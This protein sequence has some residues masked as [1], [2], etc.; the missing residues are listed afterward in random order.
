VCRVSWLAAAAFVL[1]ALSQARAQVSAPGG[2]GDAGAG[3]PPPSFVLDEDDLFRSDPKT[4]REIRDRLGEFYDRHKLP[5]YLA[6]YVGMIGSDPGER[7]ED[8]RRAWLGERYGFVLVYDTDTGELGLGRPIREPGNNGESDPAAEI[9]RIPSYELIEVMSKVRENLGNNPDRV[10]HLDDLTKLL[11]T[12]FD[13]CLERLETPHRRG[14]MLMFGVAV[15]GVIAMIGLVA[16]F[17]SRW[18]SRADAQAGQT[19]RFPNV[20]VG[21][22]LGAP[23]GGGRVSSREFREPGG[24][25]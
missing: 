23:C 2:F 12:E 17:A 3:D 13:A 9:G 1:A 22:R 25:S 6:V 4:L 10:A 11:V 24:D 19:L 15:V 20:Q 8:L 7:A 5:V 18:I 16:M 14:P 21:Q